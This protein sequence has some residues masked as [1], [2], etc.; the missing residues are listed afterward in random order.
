ML[1]LMIIGLCAAMGGENICATLCGIICST[2]I[3][4]LSVAFQ[5]VMLCFSFP[6]IQDDLPESVANLGQ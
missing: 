3:M 4:G 1:V 6:F 5:I 2:I